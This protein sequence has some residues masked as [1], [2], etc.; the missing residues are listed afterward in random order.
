MRQSAQAGYGRF[1]KI[2]HN[3]TYTTT[4]GHLNS[5]ER[6]LRAGSWVKQGQ[7]I[8]RVGMSGMATGPHLDFRVI[9]NGK[10][11]NPLAMELPKASPVPEKQRAAFLAA[12]KP[13]FAQ[14]ENLDRALALASTNGTVRALP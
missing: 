8:G 10:F 2:Q 1:I 11:I 13:A 7:T 3:G 5:Y 4:Y 9:R 6:G 14:L 12:I